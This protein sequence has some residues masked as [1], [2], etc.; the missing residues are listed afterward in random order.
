MMVS[1]VV[2]IKE[3]EKELDEELKQTRFDFYFTM[4]AS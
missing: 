3:S 1:M 4:M 2:Q